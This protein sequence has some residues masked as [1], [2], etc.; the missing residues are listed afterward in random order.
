[1]S[2]DSEHAV[3]RV[4]DNGVGI[5]KHQHEKIFDRFYRNAGPMAVNVPGV[6]LGLYISRQLAQNHGGTLRVQRSTPGEGTVFALELPLVDQ[7]PFS[8]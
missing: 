4:E 5:A 7:G 2:T 8:S 3:V 6:G 1:M